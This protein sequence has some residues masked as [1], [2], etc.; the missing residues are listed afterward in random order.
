MTL[1][2][3]RTAL[4]AAGV[5]ALLSFTAACGSSGPSSAG[6]GVT[7]WAL[8]GGDEQTFRTSFQDDK[9]DGQ[10]FGN[11]AYKQKIRSAVGAGQAP[12]LLFS[13]GNGGML[14]SWVDA[15][16]V[17]DLTP[18]VQKDPTLTSRYLPSVARTG[19]IDG[20]TYAVPNNGMQ[21]VV[22]F[23]N[24]D[25]FNKIGAQ[26]PKTWDDLMALV[27]KF[28]Q[29]GIAPFA[30][31]GQ[32]KWPQLM[33]EEYL[34]DRIGGP[35]VFNAI[36]AN[37][38]N[39]WSDPAVIQANTMIQQLVDADGFVKGFNSIA[40]DSNADT[41]LLF[42]GKA[43]MYLM[44]SWAFPTIKQADA[45]FISGGKLGY[46]TF[47]T[48]AGGKGAPADIV[49]NPANYWSISATAGDQQK[50]AAV[51]YLR[52]GVMNDSYVDSLLANGS[53]PPVN[54]IEAKLAKAQDPQYLSY[55]YNMASKAPNFQLSWDQALSPGQADTLLNNLGQLFLKQITPEQFSATM[56][57]TIGK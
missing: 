17:M 47:P 50:Q 30:M 34:V 56:N 35:G 12:S 37:R 3:R 39:A 33:W 9:V 49:G 53:V 31:G 52:T 55:V 7:A 22:L 18:E 1:G 28:N 29:A 16:K 25:L 41:A 44:G 2:K 23:Y 42:T 5:A 27:P 46:T 43:A 15:G 32:S 45:Q 40:T 6:G 21:P 54:G 48:V 14:K 24:K 36:A 11:D 4:M 10:F 19:V 8:T 38:P 51:Q 57:A 20:K 26:P 13:W